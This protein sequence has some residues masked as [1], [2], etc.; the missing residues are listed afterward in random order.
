M[1]SH[2][3]HPV[4]HYG[5]PIALVAIVLAGVA[6]LSYCAFAHDRPA[7]A[8]H[9]PAHPPTVINIPSQE[10]DVIEAE[11][12]RRILPWWE[13]KTGEKAY[14]KRHLPYE[15]APPETA[16]YTPVTP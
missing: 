1:S 13:V 12:V 15:G 7:S 8:A 16:S 5:E 2:R 14:F 10:G 9:P 6:W 3:E 4:F 11:E